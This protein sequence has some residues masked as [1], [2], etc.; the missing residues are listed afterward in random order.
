MTESTVY[1]PKNGDWVKYGTGDKA[2]GKNGDHAEVQAYKASKTALSDKTLSTSVFL[3]I[4]DKAPCGES[5]EPHFRGLSKSGEESFIF[6]IDGA[7]YPVQ[8]NVQNGDA[9]NPNLE[10]VI[11]T[12]HWLYVP[13]PQTP[14]VLFYH[15]GVVFLN[16]RPNNFPASPGLF[17]KYADKVPP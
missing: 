12:S 15:L 11:P 2:I 9:I 8:I 13:K 1:A 17:L 6:C 7:T 3:F 5:C 10:I 14:F 4:Q 16:L